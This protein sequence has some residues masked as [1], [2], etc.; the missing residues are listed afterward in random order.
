MGGHV[1]WWDMDMGMDMNMSMKWYNVMYCVMY[2]VILYD[3]NF[4][5]ML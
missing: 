3:I 1:C 4:Y 5:Y 2:N